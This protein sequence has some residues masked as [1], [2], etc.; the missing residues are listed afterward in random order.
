MD[1][2]RCFV[3]WMGAVVL[4]GGIWLSSPQKNTRDV[5]AFNHGKQV[6]KQLKKAVNRVEMY[7]GEEAE[8]LVYDFEEQCWYVFFPS[9]P[10]LVGTYVLKPVSSGTWEW[11]GE[12]FFDAG[13]HRWPWSAQGLYR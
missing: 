9:Q 2:V 13:D 3:I 4:V 6:L 7:Q 10:E 11:M 5:M 8:D 1:V 12:G